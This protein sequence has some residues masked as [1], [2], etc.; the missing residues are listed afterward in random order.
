M[1]KPLLLWD[2]DDVLNCLIP[3]CI[4]T[5]AQKL[6]PGIKMEDLQ[7]NPPLQELGCSLDEYRQILDECRDQ[8][9]YS[10]PPR[11]EVMD[12]FQEWGGCFRSMTLSS[13]PMHMAP[14]SAEWVLRHFGSWI[15]GTVF[16][17]SPR[18]K[19]TVGSHLFAS[20]AEAVVELDGILIDDMPINV[21]SVKKAGG[22]AF[23][24]PAPWNIN[25]NM[26]IEEFFSMLLK[27][28]DIT[29]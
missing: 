1:K 28:L 18:K 5:T 6:K 8:Y 20:K 19:I 15:Q 7:N 26:S 10:E 21:E 25:K 22:R 2:I 9:L 17:P 14:R 23:Y 16:V 3:L 13:S 12:F 4:S 29:K 27:E 24:F 11:K